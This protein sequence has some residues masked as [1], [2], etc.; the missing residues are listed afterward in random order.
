MKR[1]KVFLLVIVICY[2]FIFAAFAANPTD[3]NQWTYPPVEEM[4]SN[5]EQKNDNRGVD[6]SIYRS[7]YHIPDSTPMLPKGVVS[8]GVI[9]YEIRVGILVTN[10]GTA[11]ANKPVA[12]STTAMTANARFVSGDSKTNSHGQAFAYF[13]VRN[14][15]S[16]PVKV[17][18]EGVIANSSIAIPTNQ[19]YNS[20]FYITYYIVADEND[21]SGSKTMSVPGISGL[22]K[23]AFISAVRLNGS[24]RDT[25]GRFIAYYDGVYSLQAPITASGTT[26]TEGT[27]IAVDPYYIPM[28]NR[29]GWKRGVVDIMTTG[30]RR[31]EDTGGAINDF[32][33][34]VYVG[35]GL[36]NV[37]E[38]NH[39][40][41]VMY[42]GVNTWNSLSYKTQDTAERYWD[43]ADLIADED[44]IQKIWRSDERG[45]CAFVSKKDYSNADSKIEVTIAEAVGD[46][47]TLALLPLSP[48]ALDLLDVTF[49]DET[50]V[51]IES[52]IN[53]STNIYEVFDLTTGAVVAEYYGYG[54]THYGDIIY[55]V[56]APQHFSGV[57]GNN[58][59][60]TS[61]GTLIY[62]SDADTTI[63]ADIV[64]KDGIIYFTE[65][66]C[67]N[68]EKEMQSIGIDHVLQARNGNVYYY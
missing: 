26:P 40:T 32:H 68:S 27:T 50:H 46:K 29:N 44:N 6:I 57:R 51:G 9:T 36:S 7:A 17:F 41:A 14:L 18:C 45:L 63:D 19:L 66:D 20:S 15:S 39:N 38:N 10:N 33:I 65:S 23:P 37:T 61:T 28:V 1:A 4:I 49:I 67:E 34:D 52:H 53:P 8:D 56:Q 16:L 2:S 31:A 47:N 42:E 11:C 3:K 5:S 22:F 55:Y 25:S 48:F 62:E 64:V 35:I 24:G 13:H 58:R 54:F 60:I 21:Y 43:D 12:W 59:I 30:L